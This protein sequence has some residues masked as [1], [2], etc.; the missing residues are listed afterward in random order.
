MAKK[1]VKKRKSPDRILPIKKG[2]MSP[3]R[4]YLRVMVKIPEEIV[5]R[6]GHFARQ[7][8]LGGSEAIEIVL[9]VGLNHPEE[10]MKGRTI[11]EKDAYDQIPKKILTSLKEM[12]IIKPVVVGADSFYSQR[13]IMLAKTWLEKMGANA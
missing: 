6:I 10:M 13:Q 2:R 12:G 8:E 1:V 11:P 3:G 7:N 4:K 9:S 5:D